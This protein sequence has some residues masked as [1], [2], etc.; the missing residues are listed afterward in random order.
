MM[1]K[2]LTSWT[3]CSLNFGRV[4]WEKNIVIVALVNATTCLN[5][6]EFNCYVYSV[7]LE[8]ITAFVAGNAYETLKAL[9]RSLVLM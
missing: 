8:C 5:M 9:M 6:F 2:L 3:N 1:H 4:T 7:V